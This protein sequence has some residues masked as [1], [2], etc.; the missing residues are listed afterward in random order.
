MKGVLT[1]E[2]HNLVQM[3]DDAGIPT[4][5]EVLLAELEKVKHKNYALA[6]ALRRT[7]GELK[8]VR[9]ELNK[10]TR[11]KQ[12]TQK[13]FYKNGKRGTKFNG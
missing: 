5:E 11:E 10:L 3:M 4:S 2:N 1:M 8:E 6:S 9:R 12:K 7:R 13:Q